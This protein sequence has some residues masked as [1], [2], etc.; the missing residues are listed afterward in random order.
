MA[1]LIKDIANEL[2]FSE[3]T[4]CLSLNGKPGVSEKTRSL[5]LDAASR[6]G[7]T[8]HRKNSSCSILLLFYKKTGTIIYDTPFFSSLVEGVMLQAAKCGIGVQ[9]VNID[10]SKHPITPQKVSHLSTSPYS[11]VILLAEELCDDDI[12][13]FSDIGCPLVCLDACFSEKRFDS[14]C[15]D[16]QQG[17]ALAVKHLIGLGHEDIV[18]IGPFGE[19]INY[20]DRYNGFNRALSTAGVN[21]RIDNSFCVSPLM[22]DA[23][24][25]I[26]RYISETRLPSAFFCCNDIIAMTCIQALKDS[27]IRVPEDVSVVGFDDISSGILFRP[28]L[29]TVHVPAK[30]MSMLAVQRLKDIIDGKTS[31]I[32]STLVSTS[33]VVRNSTA[34]AKTTHLSEGEIHVAN[35]AATIAGHVVKQA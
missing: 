10:G 1:V 23:Y 35:D 14:I 33:L 22:D 6:L 29:T 19:T 32:V 4:V 27:G 26:C 28:T 2:G 25:D 24:N 20:I 11:G 7:Y 16:N 34:P 15:V 8:K 30:S 21:S 9:I 3:A 13:L 18:C 5:V 12:S 31:E 17:A